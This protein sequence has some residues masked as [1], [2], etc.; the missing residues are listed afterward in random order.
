MVAKPPTWMI[1]LLAVEAVVAAAFLLLGSQMAAAF[2]P[3]GS[4][5]MADILVLAIPLIAVGMCGGL[6]VFA[7]RAGRRALGVV[8]AL[9]PLPLA[10][11]LYGAFAIV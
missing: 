3:P 1:I 9:I 7:W 11:A 10:F 6:T 8:L 2:G 4:L 5:R